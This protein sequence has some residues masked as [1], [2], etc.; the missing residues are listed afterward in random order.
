[1]T[2]NRE[3]APPPPDDNGSPWRTKT[4]IAV[5]VLFLLGS[6]VLRV[7]DH[8]D[9]VLNVLACSVAAL[10]ALS[11]RKGANG[12][13]DGFDAFDWFDGDGGGD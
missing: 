8:H 10:I 7:L 5:A 13:G 12:D 6:L 2:E 1:M 4:L 11:Q 3:P 9:V